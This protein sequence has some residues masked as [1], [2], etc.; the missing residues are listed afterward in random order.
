M[1]DYRFADDGI[2]SQA[3]RSCK[4]RLL[5]IRV[6]IDIEDI[7]AHGEPKSQLVSLMTPCDIHLATTDQCGGLVDAKRF[8]RIWVERATK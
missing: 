1:G 8:S 5:Y 2:A 4:F 3:S 6:D 7:A